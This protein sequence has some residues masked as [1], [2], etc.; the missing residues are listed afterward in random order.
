MAEFVM[1]NMGDLELSCEVAAIFVDNAPEYIRS[2][3]N[4]L[5]T[6]DAEILRE[7]AHKLK[8]AAAN[9]SLSILS[10]TALMIESAA[11]AADLEK[12]SGL[13]PVMEQRFEQAIQAIRKLL[14]STQDEASQ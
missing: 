5:D 10:E 8:G 13:L 3:R 4:A 2:I 11:E 9:L 7:S 14:I 12:A 6:Q 1:R